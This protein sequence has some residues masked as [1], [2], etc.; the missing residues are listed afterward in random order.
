M[1]ICL[2][3]FGTMRLALVNPRRFY[4]MAERGDHRPC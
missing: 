1:G 2:S 4:A 3:V